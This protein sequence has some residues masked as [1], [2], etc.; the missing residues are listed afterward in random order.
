MN[1]AR[2]GIAAARACDR[3]AAGTMSG[4]QPEWAHHERVWIGFPAI[5]EEWGDAFDAARAQIADF[6]RAIADGGAGEI[7]HLICN[8][9]RDAAI[10]RDLVGSDVDVLV[11]PLGDVWLRDTA[12]II[13]GSGADRR[14]ADFRFNGWGEKYL[15]PGDQDIGRRLADRF[16]FYRDPHDWVLE[17]GGIDWDGAG[18]VVTTEQCLLNPNRNPTLA[19]EAIER[20]LKSALGVQ[21]VLW[22]GEGLY[23]DH[24][25]GHVDNLARF[26]GPRRLMLPVASGEDDPNAA[27]YADAHA[28]AADWDVDIV[29]IP[30]P[31]RVML[32]GETLPAS[33]MNFF[34]GNTVVAMPAYGTAYDDA[35]AAVLADCFPDRRIVPLPSIAILSGGGSFHCTSQ[36]VPA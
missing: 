2:R 33:Y 1:S 12:P 18:R 10:A 32:D 14:A 22:L 36:Q 7:V 21:Q 28:R 8:T 3:K 35:A 27:I 16:A 31:G 13:T 26:V 11:E 6:G 34:I 5:R 9:P 30:S 23:G 29:S 15:M 4:P 20:G 24:T 25:D 19:R 17:G